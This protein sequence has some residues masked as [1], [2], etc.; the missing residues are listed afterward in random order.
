VAEFMTIVPV[1]PELTVNRPPKKFVPVNVRIPL[2][3][4]GQL[5]NAADVPPQSVCATAVSVGNGAIE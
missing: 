5:V 1:Q 4:A 2:L 3:V